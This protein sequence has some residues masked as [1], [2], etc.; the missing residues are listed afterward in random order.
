[1][2]EQVKI[3]LAWLRGDPLIAL[4]IVFGALLLAFALLIILT[5]RHGALLSRERRSRAD[6][7]RAQEMQLAE[8]R[9]RL[10]QIGETTALRQEELARAVGERLDRVSQ[11]L[12]GCVEETGR[13]TS[14][15]LGQMME[16]SATRQGELARNLDERL[17]RVSRN[18]SETAEET[19]RRGLERVTQATETATLRQDD[20]LRAVDDRLDRVSRNL[21]ES[22]E[23]MS[24]R[25]LER[26]TQTTETA[27]LRQDELLRAVDD[28]LDRVSRNLAESMEAMNR[29]GSER[30]A[31]ATEIATLRQEELLRTI[32][33]RL[34]RV[35]QHLGA[36]VE[37]TSRRTSDNLARLH[38]RLAVIDD[39]QR[40]IAELSGRVV[41]LQDILANKQAR[42]AFGQV[43]MEAIVEDGLP[44]GVY[45]F[46]PT[47]SNGKRPD[48]LIQLSN[49]SA[50][51]VV[52]AKFP[53]EGFEALRTA[54]D[55]ATRAQAQARVRRDVTRHIDDIAAKYFIP[56]ETQDTALM[57]VPA[58]S[59]YAELHDGF[60]DLIQKAHRAR[61]VIV[62][63]NMLML[64]VQTMMAI[65]KDVR[66]REQAGV[67]QREVGLLVEDVAK[68]VGRV[69]E[70]QRRFGQL[71]PDLEK[72]I[73]SSGRIADRG[74]RIEALEVEEGKE[75]ARP[76]IAAAE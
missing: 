29:R 63:P 75:G 24:R 47:L 39:A 61:I 68:L 33:D 38:E 59:I 35:T 76:L 32:N 14:E 67:I 36:S 22:M 56:G 4:A 41:S 13:R 8:L 50:A 6:A 64:A 49:A 20:L 7:A 21:A 17:D 5:I 26:V 2:D 40:N 53:L 42:G 23:A 69:A 73:T 71:G 9:G 3:A 30:L 1:M 60:A 72:I 19:N 45:S 37:E 11:H 48:C 16:I 43:R 10:A 54:P 70:F 51:L 65:L 57:F 62:S 52:D 28:R 74:R 15:W 44:K 12:G 25:G 46:Q 27:S 31:Q 66:T 58:E 34:D 18:L 55:E